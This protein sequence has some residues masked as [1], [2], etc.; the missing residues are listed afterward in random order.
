ML[1]PHLII[2]PRNIPCFLT[3]C[4][5]RC[6]LQEAL[7]EE[8]HR[9]KLE[10]SELRQNVDRLQAQVEKDAVVLQQKA[11]VNVQIAVYDPYF[12]EIFRISFPAATF[13]NLALRDLERQRIKCMSL[14]HLSVIFKDERNLRKLCSEMEEN[15]EAAHKYRAE[16]SVSNL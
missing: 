8:S 5:F 12:I 4:C 2:L 16:N 7:Q 15:L 9:H 1:L 3:T 13:F 14:S 10:V 6:S 11:Q